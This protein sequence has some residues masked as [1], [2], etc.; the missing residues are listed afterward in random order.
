MSESEVKWY[1]YIP[2]AIIGFLFAVLI[3]ASFNQEWLLTPLDLPAP[4]RLSL[5]VFSLLGG[6]FFFGMCQLG[7]YIWKASLYLVD[8]FS[9]FTHEKRSET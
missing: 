6:M 5:L 8:K 4:S 9:T 1:L 3:I 2:L 7:Y